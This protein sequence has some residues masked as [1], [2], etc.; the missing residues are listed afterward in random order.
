VTVSGYAFLTRFVYQNREL[1]GCG[2]V[3]VNALGSA[4][5]HFDR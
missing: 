4:H 2:I 5:G 3:E 1:A